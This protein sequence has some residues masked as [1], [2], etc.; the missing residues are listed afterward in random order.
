MNIDFD[1]ILATGAQL[2]DSAKKTAVDL[3]NKGKKQ[4]D[5]LN[6]QTRLHKTQRQLGA[7]VYSLAKNGEENDLL[8]K[9]YVEAISRIE[10]E[11]EELKKREAEQTATESANSPLVY[12]YTMEQE[13]PAAETEKVCPQCGALVEE[14]TLFCNHCGTQL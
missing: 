11:I 9:K 5:L 12:T 13:E 7:L 2:A 8:V 14:D 3:A 4:V 10:E 6:A 1:K